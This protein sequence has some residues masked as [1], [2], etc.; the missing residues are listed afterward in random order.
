[1]QHAEAE[2]EFVLLSPGSRRI[3]V[4]L[5]LQLKQQL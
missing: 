5:M 2:V 3:L 1:M 4:G